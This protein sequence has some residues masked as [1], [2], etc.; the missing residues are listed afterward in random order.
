MLP[1]ND[2]GI[3]RYMHRISFDT[4]QIEQKTTSPAML[5]L[6]RVISCSWN[7][8]TE[9]LPSAEPRGVIYRLVTLQLPGICTYRLAEMGG[10]YEERRWDGLSCRDKHTVFH[11]DWLKHSKHLRG[12]VD[13]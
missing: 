8:H 10:I 2:E 5:L 7:V 12:V 9:P 3:Y 11:E 1:S 4:T 13:S 6:L